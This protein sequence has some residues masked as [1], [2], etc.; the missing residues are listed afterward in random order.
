MPAA[1]FGFWSVGSVCFGLLGSRYV[2]MCTDM[3][4][5]II[6]QKSKKIHNFCCFVTSLWLLSLKTDDVKVPFQ[7]TNFLLTS[8]K[9]LTKRAGSTTL[10]IGICLVYSLPKHFNTFLA[11]APLTF[12]FSLYCE[13]TLEWGC[14]CFVLSLFCLHNMSCPSYF[15]Y[16]MICQRYLNPTFNFSLHSAAWLFKFSRIKIYCHVAPFQNVLVYFAQKT[17]CYFFYFF[18]HNMVI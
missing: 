3:D 16:C 4:P 5:S 7:K 15:K 11:P 12:V 9:P 14:Q 1:V 10:A 13:D 17:T 8:W 2:I 6:K 18:C